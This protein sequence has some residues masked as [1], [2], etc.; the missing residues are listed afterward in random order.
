MHAVQ[1]RGR[2]GRGHSACCRCRCCVLARKVK[3]AGVRQP[4]GFHGHAEAACILLMPASMCRSRPEAPTDCQFKGTPSDRDQGVRRGWN[5]GVI[6]LYGRAYDSLPVRR[7]RTV[8]RAGAGRGGGPTP[9]PRGWS[10]AR[11]AR[12]IRA[13]GCWPWP[14]A[15]TG[16][17]RGRCLQREGD[18]DQETRRRWLSTGGAQHRDGHV[19]VGGRF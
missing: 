5:D 18:Q 9:A 14:A 7:C 15:R 16:G 11:S 6:P 2:V 8:R 3:L 13:R 4:H 10:A 1:V 19:L 17:P 12:R